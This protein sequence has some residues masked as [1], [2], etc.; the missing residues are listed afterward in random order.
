[1]SKLLRRTE[2]EAR[3]ARVRMGLLR[4]LKDPAWKVE[5]S[6][7]GERRWQV[8]RRAEGS[9]EVLLNAKAQPL[10]FTLWGALDRAEALNQK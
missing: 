8:A 7:T 9:V 2:R 10:R 1:M 3:E 4:A 5:P 6:G